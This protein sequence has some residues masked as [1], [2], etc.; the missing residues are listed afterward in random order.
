MP[1][2]QSG[3]MKANARWAGSP[4]GAGGRAGERHGLLYAVAEHVEAVDQ[5]RTVMTH[6]RARASDSQGGGG[7]DRVLGCPV[8]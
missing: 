2:G 4:A 3:D 5:C 6:H 1:G 7:Q 8:T